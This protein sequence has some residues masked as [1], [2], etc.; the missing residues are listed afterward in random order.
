MLMEFSIMYLHPK[1]SRVSV[2]ADKL[3]VSQ[4]IKRLHRI[5]DAERQRCDGVVVCVPA[6]HSTSVTCKMHEMVEHGLQRNK[7]LK[8]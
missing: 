5:K 1:M 3:H 4:R 8:Q 7:A 2:N 6:N